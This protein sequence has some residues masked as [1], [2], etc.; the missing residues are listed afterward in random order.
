MPFRVSHT[1]FGLHLLSILPAEI[2]LSPL[3]D[4]A[5][6]LARLAVRRLPRKA[7]TAPGHREDIRQSP[8]A[9]RQALPTLRSSDCRN[10][11]W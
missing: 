9:G 6:A 2:S 10:A 3:H 1:G 4:P 11:S 7:P 8:L 5:A